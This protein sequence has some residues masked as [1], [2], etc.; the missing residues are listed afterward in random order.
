MAKRGNA[1]R[2]GKGEC[3]GTPKRDG[4]GKGVGNKGTTRQPPKK[5]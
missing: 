4:S 5:K 2:G 3:G 1:G